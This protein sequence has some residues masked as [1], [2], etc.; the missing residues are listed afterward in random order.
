MTSE[1]WEEATEVDFVAA[2]PGDT[3]PAPPLTEPANEKPP[4]PVSLICD[5]CDGYGE[6]DPACP[7]CAAVAP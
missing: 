4:A 3:E 1:Q 6:H 7:R 5:L 2:K